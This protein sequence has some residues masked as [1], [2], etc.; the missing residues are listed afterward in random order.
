[1]QGYADVCNAWLNEKTTYDKKGQSTQCTDYL[2]YPLGVNG[3][4]TDLVQLFIHAP[5]GTASSGTF[6]VYSDDTIDEPLVEVSM[7][8]R[9]HIARNV[10]NVCLMRT[11]DAV[12]LGIYVSLPLL[13]LGGLARKK[14]FSGSNLGLF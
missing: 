2:Q 8:Y 13:V 3:S 14:G 9:N 7:K 1:M 4:I 5:Q 6:T 10:T 12:G 11:V